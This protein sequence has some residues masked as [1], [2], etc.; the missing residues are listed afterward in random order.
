[1]RC[2]SKGHFFLTDIICYDRLKLY[3][4]IYTPKMKSWVRHWLTPAKKQ[5][6]LLRS[7]RV[8]LEH[9]SLIKLLCSVMRMWN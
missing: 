5:T 1:M 2:T 8:W 9:K 6:I 3:L 7:I 4:K